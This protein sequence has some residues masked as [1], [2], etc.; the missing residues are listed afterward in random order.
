[1]KNILFLSTYSFAKPRHGGQIR[2]H[3]LVKKFK[4][5]GWKTRSIAVYEQESFIGDELG[6]FD[7][8]L[9]VDSTFR[10]FKGRNIPLINDLLTGSYAASETGGVQ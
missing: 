2:L 1:M 10:L 4:E 9:P 7:V 6:T 5:N 3:Q 8:P